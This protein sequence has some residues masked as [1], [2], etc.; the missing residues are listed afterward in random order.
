[1][2]TDNV[3]TLT[4]RADRHMYGHVYVSREELQERGLPADMKTWDTL[5]CNGVLLSV[6]ASTGSGYLLWP[7]DDK[8]GPR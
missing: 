5:L 3:P 7:A 6:R 4:R 8:R 2:R 1:M